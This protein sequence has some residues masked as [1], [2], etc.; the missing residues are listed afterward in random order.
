M[1]NI[2]ITICARGGSKGLKRKN[3]RTINNKPLI[4]YTL[5]FVKQLSKRIN[6]H[7]GFSTEDDEILKIV[8]Q[9]GFDI[10]YIRPKKL[11]SDN[12]GKV[13][14]I[15]HLVDYFQKKNKIEY[16]IV[17]DLDV[18]SPLRKIED[19]ENALNLLINDDF[20]FNIFSVTEAN[21]NPYFNIVEKK[22]NGYFDTVKKGSFLTRQDSPKVYDMCSSFYIYK[23]EF[24]VSNNKTTTDRSLIYPVDHICF[25]IDN[26]NDFD[27][28]SFLME[29]GNVRFI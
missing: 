21:R 16:D 7:F 26:I 8:K 22:S 9:E 25:D 11:A 28:M 23:K 13:E 4:C 24:F 17:I 6:A 29:S 10:S 14:V 3:I 15:K 12:S 2:I 27:Y 18:T 5:D 19:V 20:A 1:K